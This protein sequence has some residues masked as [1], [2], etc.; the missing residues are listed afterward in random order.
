MAYSAHETRA[1]NVP[2]T[3]RS[4]D[5]KIQITVDQTKPLPSGA[6][7]RLVGT[8]ELQAGVETTVTVSNTGTDGFV[9]LDALQ[10]VME[11]NEAGA[12]KK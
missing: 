1:T 4:G 2:V 11:G 10:F 12:D 7:F 5:K 9:I 3:I 6:V 8:V